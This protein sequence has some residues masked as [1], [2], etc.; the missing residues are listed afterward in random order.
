MTIKKKIHKNIEAAVQ[1]LQR[2]T[3]RFWYPPLIGF[4]A[5]ID[6]FIIIIPTDGILISS[7]MLK[8]KSWLYLSICISIGS[9]LGA[10]MFFYIV[11][12]HGLPFILDIYPSLNQGAMWQWS[13]SFFQQYG[14][15]L[16]FFVAATPLMQQPAI[17]LASLAHTPFLHVLA[18]VFAG[19]TI[20]YLVM[21]YISSHSPRLLS[22]LWGVKG[23]LDEIG[24][25]LDS[26]IHKTK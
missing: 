19:R 23:E 26:K 7:A 11:E 21:S 9:T 4:L 16:V 8:P 10:L 2:F 5:L 1:N 18:V 24:I 6:N 20:K 13:E 3:D 22:K 15:L 17:I 12:T 25:H 14:L